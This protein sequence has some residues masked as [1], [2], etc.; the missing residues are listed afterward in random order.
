MSC[1]LFS[2]RAQTRREVL[3][4]N[5]GNEEFPRTGRCLVRNREKVLKFTIACG[6]Y[7]TL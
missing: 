7:S 2:L 5:D 4:E 3:K 6:S 1:M